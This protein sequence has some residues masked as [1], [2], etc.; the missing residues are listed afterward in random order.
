MP[1]TLPS[2]AARDDIRGETFGPPDAIGRKPGPF[3][4]PESRRVVRRSHGSRARGATMSSLLR[5]AI[6]AA[7]AAV[8][9]GA[10]A[11]DISLRAVNRDRPNEGPISIYY[12]GPVKPGDAQ[13]L[14]E[15][16]AASEATRRPF[17]G[18]FLNSPGGS[19]KEALRMAHDIRASGHTTAVSS[20]YECAS[21]CF[22]LVAAGRE[23]MIFRGA[24]IGV[25][26]AADKGIETP[27]AAAATLTMAREAAQLGVPDSV[28]GHMV[29]TRASSMQWL[30]RDE[31]SALAGPGYSD[32]FRMN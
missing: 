23:K 2:S 14:A 1:E 30:T 26:S 12:S 13:R 18:I 22:L 3:S 28:I 7:M 9:S 25:H 27:E 16:L 6:L 5:I 10:M 24:R 21:A 32:T 15:L 29:A 19:I 31:L 8:T 4:L 17:L 20:N 11:A